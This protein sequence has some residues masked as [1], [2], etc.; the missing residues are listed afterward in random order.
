[1]A[2]PLEEPHLNIIPRTDAEA[3]RIAAVTALTTDFGAAQPFEENAAGAAT[4]RVLPNANAFSQPSGNIAFAFG[5][6]RT[7]AAPAAFSSKGW[8]A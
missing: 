2:G 1:M 5:S 7:V 6:T 4:V 3:A 8:A